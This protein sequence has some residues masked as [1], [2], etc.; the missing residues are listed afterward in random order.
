MTLCQSLMAEDFIY[1]ECNVSI[2]IQSEWRT[3]VVP[4]LSPSWKGSS[5][6]RRG[7]GGGGAGGWGRGALSQ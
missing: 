4:Y 5:S 3:T 6:E 1:V 2:I 7:G